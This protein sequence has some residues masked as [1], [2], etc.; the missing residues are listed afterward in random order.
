MNGAKTTIHDLPIPYDSP[1][2]H[3]LSRMVLPTAPAAQ[4]KALLGFFDSAFEFGRQYPEDGVI[5]FAVGRAATLKPAAAA[6]ACY[7]QVLLQCA[8]VEPGCLRYVIPE[9]DRLSSVGHGLDLARLEEVLNSII[10]HHAPLGHGSEVAWGITG[11]LRFGRPMSATASTEV[12]LI[13][14]PVVALPF[15]HALHS[16]LVPTRPSLTTV[17]SF[18]TTDDLYAKQWLLSYEANVK[19]WLPSVGTADHVRADPAFASLK[20]AGVSFYN[21]T[22]LAAP[23]PAMPYAGAGTYAVGAYAG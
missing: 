9:L 15:L 12:A 5:A 16:G 11:L 13:T 7:E 3:H 18:M 21:P 14:D 6:L 8:L 10:V 20:T 17:S 19:G 22:V 1:W 4:A 23:I 2:I